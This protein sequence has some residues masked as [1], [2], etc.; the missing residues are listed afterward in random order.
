MKLAALAFFAI[1]LLASGCGSLIPSLKRE[2]VAGGHYER[3]SAEG[4]ESWIFN[5]DGTL[6][7]RLT[8]RTF[9]GHAERAKWSLLYFDLIT[10]LQLDG[11]TPYRYSDGKL[12]GDR[13]NGYLLKNVGFNGQGPA[14]RLPA[15]TDGETYMTR[16]NP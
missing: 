4:V 7:H 10:C 15:Y 16:V 1:G 3:I 6:D 2:Q 13:Q 8:S 12:Q 11:Y 9:G 5:V 14:M